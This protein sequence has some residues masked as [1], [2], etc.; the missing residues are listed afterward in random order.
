M[1][2][3]IYV[4]LLL[5]LLTEQSTNPAVSRHDLT[6]I[7]DAIYHGDYKKLQ[8]ILKPDELDYN[9]QQELLKYAEYIEKTNQQNAWFSSTAKNVMRGALCLAFSGLLYQSVIKF[10]EWSFIVDGMMTNNQR[11][12]KVTGWNANHQ[13]IYGA[14][15]PIPQQKIDDTN[16]KANMF[17]VLGLIAAAPIILTGYDGLMGYYSER[18][19]YIL[20]HLRTMLTKSPPLRVNVRYT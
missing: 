9:E 10:A 1:A 5:G 8:N 17:A 2:R 20:N 16:R 7:N 4:F 3:F 15:T 11:R 12:C 14:T 6:A 18:S 19:W 13:P